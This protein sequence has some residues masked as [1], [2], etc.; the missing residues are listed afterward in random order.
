MTI[1]ASVP[2]NGTTS[3]VLVMTIANPAAP[4]VDE[5]TAVSS[6]D[7]SCYLTGDGLNPQTSENTIED[8]RLCQVQTFEARGDFTDSLELTYVFNPASPADNEAQLALPAGTSAFV[9]MRWA[10]D[11]E[12]AFGAG[13]IVDVYPVVAGIPR[14]QQPA[15][16]GVH[17]IMQKLF[18]VGEVMRDVEVVA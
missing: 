14:K 6:L 2:T 9:V 7:L 11:S 1:P 15:R 13:D 5:I 12:D 10:V 8:P 4:D 18:V 3:A 17:K 16:N